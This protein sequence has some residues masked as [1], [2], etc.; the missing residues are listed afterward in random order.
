MTLIINTSYDINVKRFVDSG[1]KDLHK[2][3]KLNI[4]EAIYGIIKCYRIL[5]YRKN[6]LGETRRDLSL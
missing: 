3:Y 2:I 4:E 5:Y 1:K 6:K